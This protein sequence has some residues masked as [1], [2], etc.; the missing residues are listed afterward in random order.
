MDTGHIMSNEK[1]NEDE[2]EEGKFN[3]F[4]LLGKTGSGKTTLLNALYKD[5]V[6]NVQKSSQSVTKKCSLYYYKLKNQKVICLIDTPGL[7]DS[8]TIINENI[9]NTHLNE[10]KDIIDKEKIEIRGILYLINFQCERFD[11]D[12][13]KTLLNYNTIFPYK[14]FWKLLIIIYTHFYKDPNDDEKIEQIKNDRRESNKNLFCQLM[15]KIKDVSDMIPYEDLNIKYLN[16]FSEPKNDKME[17]NNEKTRIILLQ[18][19]NKFSFD[20]R[21]KYKYIRNSRNNLKYNGTY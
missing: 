18:I 9:D 6:G 11:A 15:E 17:K 12:E 1:L 2:I 16:S 7:S 19:L 13:Q 8:E 21:R 14:N 20:K 5:I 3:G 10:I 4:I